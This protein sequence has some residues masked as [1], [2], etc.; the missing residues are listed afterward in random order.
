MSD[1]VLK[2]KR[3][4]FATNEGEVHLYREQLAWARKHASKHEEYS[5]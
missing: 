3:A 4:W 5:G 2:K 1:D